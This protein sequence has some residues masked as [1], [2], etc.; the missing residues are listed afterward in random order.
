MSPSK[1]EEK[2][3]NIISEDLPTPKKSESQQIV[4]KN[5]M[6]PKL[7]S[8]ATMNPTFRR[9]NSSQYIDTSRDSASIRHSTDEEEDKRSLGASSK[10]SQLQRRQTMASVL[11]TKLQYNFQ[12]NRP[13]RKLND[14]VKAITMSSDNIFAAAKKHAT[15]PQIGI[16]KENT[17]EPI[18]EDQEREDLSSM[19]SEDLDESDHDHTAVCCDATHGA[20][21]LGKE[22]HKFVH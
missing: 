17:T 22:V 12:D 19:S 1:P 11:T 9:T 14:G 20:V 10:K 16:T 5:L 15:V 6:E 2:A 8:S 21:Q 13:K 18:M 7:R 4:S 3:S